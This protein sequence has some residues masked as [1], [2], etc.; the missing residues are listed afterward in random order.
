MV[1]RRTEPAGAS[2]ITSLLCL[3]IL[4]ALAVVGTS[5]AV[6]ADEQNWLPPGSSTEILRNPP[7]ELIRSD[8]IRDEKWLYGRLLFRSPSLLGEKA[9]RIGLSC[10][11]CHSNGHVNTDFFINGL[12]D[13]PGRV[14]V[15]HR[16]WQAGFDDAISNPIDIPSLRG[17]RDT[18][19]YG[20]VNIFPTLHAFTRHVIVT[21]FAGPAP[22]SEKLESLVTYLSSLD[23][24]EL[25]N[26]QSVVKA[27]ADMSYLSLLRSPL[28]KRDSAK[29]RELTDLIRSD[30]GRRADM[31]N[32]RIEATR[33]TVKG[34]KEITEKAA[35]KEY[36]AAITIY[37]KLMSDQ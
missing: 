5:P 6:A 32:A 1:Q 28:E 9:V 11:S 3:C 8:T 37:Q 22:D 18:A 25:D 4:S 23:N 14:D 20:T 30:F 2:T 31:T 21:E 16:F 29:L 26:D 12:S 19:P 36:P 13:R 33:R 7:L 24:K 15:T 34:L 27:G 35:L 17:S 10:N